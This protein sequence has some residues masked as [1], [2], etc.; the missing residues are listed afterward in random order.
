MSKASN[1]VAIITQQ[2]RQRIPQVVLLLLNFW[3]LE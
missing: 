1:V 2:S 3:H